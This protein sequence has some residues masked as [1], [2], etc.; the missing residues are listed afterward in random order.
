MANKQYYG[1]KYPFVTDDEENF[2]LDLN[3]SLKDHVRSLIMHVIFTPK[4]QKLRDAEF[5][6][7]LIR[8]VFE[9]NDSISWEMVENEVR[10]AVAKYVPNVTINNI[11]ILKNEEE[12]SAIF[13][14]ID[15]TVSNG[16]TSTTDSIVT[17]I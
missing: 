3:K 9:P 6:T 14:R 7:N 8:F 11:E 4:G 15:Y 12:V 17:E 2:A 10:E 16:F 13:V 5:G 1:I